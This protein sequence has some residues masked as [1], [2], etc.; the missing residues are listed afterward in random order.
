[1]NNI[2]VLAFHS[3]ETGDFNRDFLDPSKSSN[4]KFSVLEGH[5]SNNEDSRASFEV[6]T[7]KMANKGLGLEYRAV[8]FSGKLAGGPIDVRLEFHLHSLLL[9]TNKSLRS[10]W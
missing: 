6:G 4:V 1:L 2:A 7:V 8:G 5:V 10:I 3:T 9:I